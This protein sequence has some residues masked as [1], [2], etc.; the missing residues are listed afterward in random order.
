V[1][2]VADAPSMRLLRLFLLTL[3]ALVLGAFATGCGGG[4]GGANHAL[5]VLH[6]LEPVAEATGKADSARFEMRFQMEMPGFGSPFAFSASGAYDTPAKR[7][8]ITMDLGSFAEFMNGLSSSFG[9]G[10]PSGDLADPSQ[11]KLEMRLDGTVA[12][13]RVPFLVSELPSGKEWVQI[14]LTAAARMQGLD[15]GELQSFAKGSD[16]RGTLD[17]LRSISGDVTRLGTEEVRGVPSTH[18]FAVVDWKKALAR[19]ARDAGQP[20][21]FD[22][23]AFPSSL[24]N[25]PV[26]V[27]VDAENLMRRMTMDFSFSSPGL[28]QQAKASLSMEL[29]D[30][31]APVMVEAPPAS[32]VVDASSLRG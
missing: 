4:Q 26:D 8:E 28:S 6:D 31:G 17:Y 9:G 14:D 2:C 24:Q 15:L 30:Y 25:V 29:F 19:S 21:L 27:W 23:L 12:Y 32:A 13:M 7:A 5:P 20:G 11:W 3:L 10:A 18:Y 22:Q 1:P 16:P